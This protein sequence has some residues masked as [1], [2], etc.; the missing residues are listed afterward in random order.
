MFS[1]WD[2]TEF[3]DC[4]R[5]RRRRHCDS[6]PR[7]DYGENC[8]YTLNVV[9]RLSQAVWYVAVALIDFVDPL[10][11]IHRWSFDCVLVSYRIDR[12]QLLDLREIIRA[13]VEKI[14]FSC[15]I[16]YGP[17]TNTH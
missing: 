5:W 3:L 13:N 2:S 6:R 1:S 14:E 11:P 7:A 17:S 15:E 16:V 10:V 9:D 8:S 4:K 12:V